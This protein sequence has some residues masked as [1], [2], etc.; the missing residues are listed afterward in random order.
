MN[1]ARIAVLAALIAGGVL[2]SFG[3][4]DRQANFASAR[5]IWSD[6]L[7]DADQ[8][9]L[10]A[11]RMP[12]DEEIDLGAKLSAQLRTWQPVDPRDSVYITAVAASLTPKVRRTSMPYTLRV[13][14]S[15]QVNAFA[16]PG[17]QIYVLRGMMDFLESEAELAAILGHEIAHVDLRHCVERYQYHR[18]LEKAGAADL[19][20]PID[21]ARSL[22]VLGYNQFQELE[23]DDEGARLAAEAGYDPAAAEAVFSRME[24]RF[25]P[26]SRAAADRPAQE[27]GQALDEALSDYF[28]TH[29]RTSDR[30]RRMHEFASRRF[31]AQSFYIGKQNYQS[32]IP[33]AKYTAPG[34]WKSYK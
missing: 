18:I 16:L 9:G 23:A 33:R 32:R 12:I 6:V 8:I 5:E 22:V 24:A 29:P 7:R 10:Q 13:I 17:G 2:A 14:E 20:L 28:S 21:L 19:S 1:A 26:T 34:E 27:L 15:P 3:I 25:G 11:T 4:Q 30:A 31:G